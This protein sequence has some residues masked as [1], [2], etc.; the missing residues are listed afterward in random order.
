MTSIR[1]NQFSF[2]GGIISPEMFG[3]LD[4]RIYANAVAEQVN[5]ITKPQGPAFFRPGFG[6][7]NKTFDQA[8]GDVALIPFVYSDEQSLVVEVG[9]KNGTVGGKGYLRMHTN[10]GTLL[11][12]IV[13]DVGEQADQVDAT[14]NTITFAAH[15]GLVS[16]QLGRFMSTG[17]M[18]TGITRAET[19]KVILVDAQTISL[20]VLSGGSYVAQAI[21]AANVGYLRFIA[22][23]QLP[24][25][26][27]TPQSLD[28]TT[29]GQ[30]WNVGNNRL[31]YTAHPF[32][33]QGN[34]AV[35]FT[36]TP[37]AQLPVELSTTKTYYIWNITADSFQ[38]VT[39]LA[40]PVI[41][42][43]SGVGSP[44]TFGV[45]RYYER[46]E[47]VYWP[48]ETGVSPG[49]YYVVEDHATGTN[50]DVT[51]AYLQ[52]G[53]GVLT[54]PTPYL[55]TQVM[56]LHYV[57]SNDVLTLTNDQHRPHELQRFSATKWVLDERAFAATLPTPVIS[58]VNEDR[59]RR[60]LVEGSTNGPTISGGPQNALIVPIM[61]T[62]VEHQFAKNDVVYVGLGVGSFIVP[63]GYYIV[64]DNFPTANSK[65]FTLRRLDGFL[66]TWSGSSLSP[67]SVYY[68][69]LEGSTTQ[70]YKV[71]AVD[72]N[73]LESEASAV[74]EADNVLFV[75][76]ASNTIY[77]GSIFEAV[78][79]RV[80]KQDETGLY[81]F[82][83]E[84]ED[85]TF[86]DNN[87]GANLDRT[88]P[89][90]DATISG[91]AFSPRAVG[92]L[93]QRRFFAGTSAQ[94]QTLFGSRTGAPSDF[95]YHLPV[96]DDDR[97]EYEL[98][99]NKAQTIRH[100][101]TL[102]DLLVFTDSGE[103]R[104]TANNSDTITPESISVR[105]QSTIGCSM[106]QPVTVNNVV[107]FPA[108][109]GGHIREMGYQQDRNG[110]ATNDMSIRAAHLFDSYTIVDMAYQKSPFPVVWAVSSNGKLLGL[111]YV[112]E[113]QVGAW[114]L[115]EVNGLVKSI[116]VVPEGDVDAVYIVVVRDGVKT[117]QRMSEV[118]NEDIPIAKLNHLDASTSTSGGRKQTYLINMVLTGGVNLQKGDTV[119]LSATNVAFSPED[120]GDDV[121]LTWD[122]I[123]YRARVTTFI[124]SQKVLAELQDAIPSESR[125]SNITSWRWAR[126]TL[127]RLWHH[128]GQ[129]LSVMADGVRLP[130]TYLVPASG[131]ITLS[132]PAADVH[133]GFRY[134]GKVRTLPGAIQQMDGAGQ[135]R[136][137]NVSRVWLRVYR[138]AG[139]RIGP[140]DADMTPVAANDEMV[141]KEIQ[142]TLPPEWQRGGQ[143]TIV[144]DEP[145]PA[146]V[147]SITAETVIGD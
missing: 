62:Q 79:Y 32:F 92:F 115:H 73:G 6:Y 41:V 39:S 3:R 141:T 127:T 56:D 124:W 144:Q 80:Y 60:I 15:H 16:N 20:E 84:T 69:S 5:F 1:T 143:I 89:F 96:I 133:V 102:A 125:N 106:V 54:V 33:G 123:E 72:K 38:L 61:I 101:V 83:G 23:G 112:P 130:D 95:S 29:A 30:L 25:G 17:T 11:W 63:E 121:V 111:T 78:Q 21:S 137:K 71:S 100:L 24:P 75:E 86:V 19:Y 59:G 13:N 2:V 82:I 146:T 22:D 12:G 147:V 55:A 14:A 50:V 109:R 42:T 66:Y 47:L 58:A 134:S 77:W 88:P 128:V 139:L 46:G 142:I 114:H 48:L 18:P 131:N 129:T 110:Y 27:V 68:S 36:G 31:D 108:A 67:F 97:I 138:S 132:E 116:A 140:T 52:T 136:E 99:A 9:E 45:V 145:L 94:P 35:R 57:Q 4:S 85:L 28:G 120:I 105:Q 98:A 87:I 65:R 51:R 34:V 74:G 76:G 40:N 37:G 91:S 90:V 113:E 43:L 44:G 119:T 117:I 93:E 81:G 26:H 53:D 126:R 70:R 104:V 49:V 107:I 122:G 118:L 135:G 10:G 7:V 64:E 103:W 8:N